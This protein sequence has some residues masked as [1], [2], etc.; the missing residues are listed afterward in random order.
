MII[1]LPIKFRLCVED[2]LPALE[3]MGLHTTQREIIRST[4]EAQ[5][6]GDAAM[7]LAISGGFPVGQ[8]WL[9]FTRGGGSK[10]PLLWAIRVF[11]PLQG[12]GLGRA[13]MRRAE[14][15]AQSR[16]AGEIELGV[17]WDNEGARRFYERLG[18]EPSGKCVE[19]VKFMFE[20]QPM[21]MTVDQ[22]IMRKQLRSPERAQ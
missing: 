13:L 10:R 16:G 20:G 4:F 22:Q 1:Q 9:D 21:E 15:L 14:A 19:E 8:A 2:D 18:Y 5:K 17:E 7:L 3:W 12:S 11:P 6:R